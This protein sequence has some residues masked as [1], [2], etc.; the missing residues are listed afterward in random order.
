[1]E[2]ESLSYGSDYHYIPVTS[3][4]SGEGRDVA[5]DVYCLT[6]QIVNVVYIGAPGGQ[7]WV[8]VDA[9]MPGSADR[10]IAAAERRFGDVPPQCLIL[11]HGHFDHVGA[12]IELLKRWN[13]PIYAHE[14][15]LRHL[16][17]RSRYPYPDA[18]VEGGLVA[19]MSPM[20]PIEPIRL[21]D[22]VQALPA[23]GE[24]PGLPDWR[25]LHTPGHTIGH[26]SLFRERDRTLI[27]GDAF[28]TVDQDSLYKVFVQK[29]E[30]S[31]PPRYL[32]PDWEAAKRSVMLLNG[33]RP[34]VAVTGHGMPME[35]DE[36]AEGLSNLALDFDRIA[37]PDYGKYVKH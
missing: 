30:V 33:L 31:G 27:A 1:M 26:I 29:R 18:L 2:N 21:S 24:V 34:Q 32:T 28:V 36:L 15:E 16:T 22:H 4:A 8:L 17:G 6:V 9:G 11:T 23:G 19:K 10:I 7:D 3:L 35:G 25:W 13:M 5:P 20:F 37:L 14:Q 12:V